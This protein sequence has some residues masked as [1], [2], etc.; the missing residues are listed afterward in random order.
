[1]N[2]RTLLGVTAAAS[3]G[4]QVLIVFGAWGNWWAVAALSL[5]NFCVAW[6]CITE[7]LA[8]MRRDRRWQLWLE[9]NTPS[10]N[11]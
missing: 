11:G 6:L 1:M 4:L 8:E 5:V 3:A 2:A 9:E 7:D 10:K